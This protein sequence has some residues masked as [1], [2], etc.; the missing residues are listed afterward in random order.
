MGMLQVGMPFL[1]LNMLLR[2][3]K[4]VFLAKLY[5]KFLR[6]DFINLV[7]TYKSSKNIKNVCKLFILNI[8]LKTD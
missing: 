8:V 2:H 3:T 4:C 7:I 6:I 5:V 1:C